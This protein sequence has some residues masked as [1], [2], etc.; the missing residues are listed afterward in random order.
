MHGKS[1]AG[2]NR[3]GAWTVAILL[4]T[5]LVLPARADDQHPLVGDL[6]ADGVANITDVLLAMR[7]ALRLIPVTPAMLAAGDVEPVPGTEAGRPWGDGKLDIAD[8]TALLR[9]VIGITVPPWPDPKDESSFS[10]IQRDIFTPSCAISSCHNSGT[11]RVGLDLSPGHAYQSLVNA[12]V[13]TQGASMATR[14]VP[15]H[16]ELSF[17]MAKL[18]AP[19]PHD[20]TL[21]PFG[22]NGLDQDT[23]ARIRAWIANGAKLDAG[24]LYGAPGGGR[25]A[26]P[27]NISLPTPGQIISTESQANG[28]VQVITAT[29]GYQVILGPFPVP[30]GQ[31]IFPNQPFTLPNDQPLDIYRVEYGTNPGTHHMYLSMDSGGTPANLPEGEVNFTN[32]TMVFVQNHYV[33][34]VLPSGVVFRMKPDQQFTASMHYVNALTQQTLNGVG[35]IVINFWTEP[36]DPSHLLVHFFQTSNGSIVIPPHSTVTFTLPYTFDQHVHVFALWGHFHSRGKEFLMQKL[37]SDQMNQAMQASQNS[38]FM[39]P[40]GTATNPGNVVYRSVTWD[41][42]LYQSY[43][44]PLDFKAA[45]GLWSTATYENDGSQTYVNGSYVETNEMFFTMGLYYIN[46]SDGG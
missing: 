16:P 15:Y 46:P 45:E 39:M 8:V 21:M 22:T 13:R 29:Q 36:V 33:N 3:I 20:G 34:Q 12:P 10:S 19:G 27:Q 35:K 18:T 37:D 26:P 14:V 7:G 23:V 31:E 32:G 43:D 40:G 6:N 28:M 1:I 4:A 9:H 17:L 44:P 38:V 25:P 24:D 41:D 5:V 42:P 30:F 11:D 2:W